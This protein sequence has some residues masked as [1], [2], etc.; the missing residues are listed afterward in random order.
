M[1]SFLYTLEPYGG[2]QGAI[3]AW[4]ITVSNADSN[5]KTALAAMLQI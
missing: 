4:L 5:Q 2:G 1:S 3:T